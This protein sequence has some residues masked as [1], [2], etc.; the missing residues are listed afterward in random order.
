MDYRMK[1][2]NCK[3]IVVMMALLVFNSCARPPEGTSD[4]D[5]TTTAETAS[6]T[7]LAGIGPLSVLD[8]D[9]IKTYAPGDTAVNF[10]EN[11]AADS[12]AEVN[13][14]KKDARATRVDEG[15]RFQLAGGEIKLLKENKNNEGDDYTAY[16]FLG[17]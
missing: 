5:T 2:T 14:F 16:S 3:R 8:L 6:Q 15:I 12:T 9:N 4:A 10:P 1:Y 11:P 17:A 7:A 13:A